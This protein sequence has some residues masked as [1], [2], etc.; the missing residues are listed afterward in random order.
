MFSKDLLRRDRSAATRL[1]DMSIRRYL[2]RGCSVVES[3]DRG[4]RILNHTVSFKYSDYTCRLDEADIEGILQE[5][6]FRKEIPLKASLQK[7]T[8]TEGS[9]VYFTQEIPFF[10]V[11]PETSR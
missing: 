3:Y 10:I 8:I 11:Y 9:T 6:G 4:D 5:L 1:K 7:N 2:Y